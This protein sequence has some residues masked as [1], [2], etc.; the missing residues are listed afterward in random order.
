[1][2]SFVPTTKANDL[3]TMAPVRASDPLFL[4]PEDLTNYMAKAHEEKLRA[5]K[6]VETKKDTE[7]MVRSSKNSKETCTRSL[8]MQSDAP[9]TP[10]ALT[11]AK[12]SLVVD[13][14]NRGKRAQTN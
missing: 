3:K 11:H 4:S 12:N 1:M 5:I 10:K 9:L 6:E 8:R 2:T 7:I 14:Q 13:A